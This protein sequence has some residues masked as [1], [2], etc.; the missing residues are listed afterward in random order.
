[1]QED[2]KQLRWLCIGHMIVAGLVALC[3]CFPIIH[4]VI[5]ILILSGGMQDSHGDG[6]PPWFGMIFVGMATMMIAMCWA[7]AVALVVVARRLEQHRSHTYCL[8]VAAVE[9][10]FVPVGTVLGVLTIV[11]LLRPSVKQLFGVESAAA[12]SS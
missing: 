3:G 11:V 4:L 5:G 10:M 12:L 8:V 6:P 9:C 2:L 1:M 7:M